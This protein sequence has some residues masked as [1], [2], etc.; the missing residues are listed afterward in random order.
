[1]I[2]FA[3]S[4]PHYGLSHEHIVILLDTLNV[5]RDQVRAGK[6]VQFPNLGICDN[7]ETRLPWDT[8]N[9]IITYRLVEYFSASW[10]ESAYPGQKACSPIKEDRRMPKWSG[11]NRRARLSLMAYMAKRLRDWKRRAK[12]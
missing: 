11:S 5:M 4:R 9:E 2:P 7:W 10:P 6:H 12:P 8:T 1:M 3:E